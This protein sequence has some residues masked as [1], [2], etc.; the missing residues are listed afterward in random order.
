MLSNSATPGRT[1]TGLVEGEIE[2]DTDTPRL[3]G[4]ELGQMAESGLGEPRA[5]NSEEPKAI[6]HGEALNVKNLWWVLKYE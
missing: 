5:K 1:P 4:T 3:T 2:E 6:Y